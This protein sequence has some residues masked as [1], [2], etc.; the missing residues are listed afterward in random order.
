[1]KKRMVCKLIK[2]KCSMGNLTSVDKYN[3]PVLFTKKQVEYLNLDSH[4]TCYL[5]GYITRKNGREKY[6][7]NL[8]YRNKNMFP[9]PV[10]GPIVLGYGAHF[11]LDLFVPADDKEQG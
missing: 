5:K 8:C 11:G 2:D 7:S 4:Q 1:M 6:S 9:E 10:R 3:I